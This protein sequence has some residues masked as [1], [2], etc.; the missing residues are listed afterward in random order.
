DFRGAFVRGLGT[1]DARGLLPIP[2]PGWQVSYSGLGKWPLLSR[3]VQNATLRHG[4]NADF[5]TDYRQNP[6]AQDPNHTIPLADYQTHYTLPSYE[7]GGIRIN[8]RFQP[9]IGVDLTWKGRLQTNFAWNRSNA[10][11]LST[12]TFE[13]GENKTSELT[14]TSTF[15]QQGMKLPFLRNRLNN[16]ISLSLTVSYATIS[17]KR[18]LL[19]NALIGSTRETF[20]LEEILSS[21]EYVKRLTA[22]NRLTLT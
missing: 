11:S 22:S 9:F 15:Q 12:S 10:Y 18:Y 6:I 7:V 13:I 4:Y 21:E 1:F 8:E 19:K 16:R 14:F 17:D 2:M 3:L 5:S 20:V